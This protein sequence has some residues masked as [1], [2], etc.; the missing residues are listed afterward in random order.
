MESSIVPK[1]GITVEMAMSPGQVNPG[2]W[3]TMDHITDVDYVRNKLAVIPEFK[4]EV[5]HVQ[6]F[7]I[8]EG[9]RIQTGPVGPQTSNGKLYPGG[10]S[11]IQILNYSDRSKLRP[12]GEPR[13]IYSH[14][15]GK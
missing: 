4:P 7:H 3:A 14:G 12:I 13:K 8:P 15:C 9:V 10:G 1:G 11:Q 6:K 5:S 2:G